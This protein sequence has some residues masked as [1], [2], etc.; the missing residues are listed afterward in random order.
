MINDQP[1]ILSV[2]FGYVFV[3]VRNLRIVDAKLSKLMRNNATE[4][5][6]D[7]V[8]RLHC[9]VPTTDLYERVLRHINVE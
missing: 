8:F 6:Y 9:I 5:E 3:L 1:I 2:I 7:W 4:A